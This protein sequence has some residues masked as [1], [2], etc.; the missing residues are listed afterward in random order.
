MTA[1]GNF[2]PTPEYGGASIATHPSAQQARSG[3]YGD[4]L[5]GPGALTNN[6]PAAVRSLSLTG[7]RQASY[8]DDYYNRLWLLPS[9]IRYGSISGLVTKVAVLWNAWTVPRTITGIV[10][11][12]TTGINL[13]GTAPPA[14]MRALSTL[15]YNVQATPTGPATVNG[16]ITFTADNGQS[17]TLYLS[18]ERSR[19][20]PIP[21]NWADGVNVTLSFKTDVFTSRSGREQRRELRQTPRKSFEFSV[22]TENEDFR[23]IERTMSKWYGYPLQMAD[24][25]RTLTAATVNPDGS[26]VI[27]CECDDCRLAQYGCP[28]T[29]ELPYWAATDASVIL[30]DGYGRIA[31]RYIASASGTTITFTDTAS[32]PWPAGTII[33]PTVVGIFPQ[34]ITV[35]NPTST[36]ATAQVTIDVTP[37]SEAEVLSNPQE[38]IH[39][40][41]EVFPI[42]PNWA[43]GLSSKWSRE[44]EQVDFG[45]GVIETYHP[46][47]FSTR[48]TTS[49]IVADNPDLALAIENFFR[50]MRGRRGEFYIPTYERDMELAADIVAGSDTIT[51][52]G[53]DTYADYSD[54]TVHRA[55]AIRLFDGRNIYRSLRSMYISGDNTALQFEGGFLSNISTADVA[56]V[57]WMTV[58]RFSS[59]DLTFSWQ[60][61]SL[62]KISMN[63]TSLED[64]TVEDPI[65]PYD[66]AAQFV[67]E[68]WGPA[69]FWQ[70]DAV[71]CLVNYRQPETLGYVWF[72]S[73]GALFD[74]V[75]NLVNVRYPGITA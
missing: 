38:E 18:G 40:G 22:L 5:L 26:M 21:P 65:T 32:P 9:L 63:T 25:T 24:P 19:L 58:A 74:T 2:L 28:S 54:S 75:D 14:A 30:D 45:R 33:R 55:V 72:E 62:V 39:N 4:T 17:I 20:W 15:T 7:A 67:R 61:E 57:S 29:C 59:D 68:V 41:R 8:F 23:R 46:T 64:L 42:R 48:I 6:R 12:G 51:V 43:T 27:A 3:Q 69:N 10:Q 53:T 35:N 50:R 49:E 36:V 60:T 34:S 66:G 1:A 70:F 47:A 37:G 11:S 71:D 52:L 13:G 73:N 31:Q 44:Y 16:T 56:Y